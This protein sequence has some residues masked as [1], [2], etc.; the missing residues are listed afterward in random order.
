MPP[1]LDQLFLGMIAQGYRPILAHVERYRWMENALPWVMKLSARGVLMQVTAGSL[2]GEYGAR[3]EYWSRNLLD[4]GL[5][6]IV[7]SDAHNVT[8]RPPGLRSAFEFVTRARGA[9]DAVRIF[10]ETPASILL[11][12][13][14]ESRRPMREAS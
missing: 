13:E 3:A 11:G 14:A 8:R 7:A 6:D 5:V 1:H 9:A 10:Q 2:L 12:R 4:N